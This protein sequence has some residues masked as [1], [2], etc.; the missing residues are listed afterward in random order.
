MELKR[1][2]ESN[3]LKNREIEELRSN[4]GQFSRKIQEYS[5]ISE[6]YEDVE[7]KIG[8]ATDE[9]ERLNRVL[10]ERNAELRDNQNKLFET[11][12]RSRTL[13]NEFTRIRSRLELEA[14]QREE[15]E[16]KNLSYE[17]QLREAGNITRK[18]AEYE[19]KLAVIDQER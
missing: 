1:S 14:G 2:K 9:I 19:N 18:I 13:E 12:I 4:I 3:E 7:S 15:A 5:N 10:K 11:E 6:K 16:T 17:T 8:M